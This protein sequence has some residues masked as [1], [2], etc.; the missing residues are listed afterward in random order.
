MGFF[1]SLFS[2][3]PALNRLAKTA[4]V[5]LNCISTFQITGESD[6]LK[7]AAW[8]FVYGIE[9]SIEKWHWNPITAKVFIP[10]HQ[11]LGRLNINQVMIIIISKLKN[12]SSNTTIENTI[13]DILEGGDVFSKYSFLVSEE[14][15]SK[16]QP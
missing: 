10:N 12:A 16:L 2:A 14:V 11:G 6:E 13:F 15:K 4:D 8:L 9:G 7:K 1:K 5:C 3:G